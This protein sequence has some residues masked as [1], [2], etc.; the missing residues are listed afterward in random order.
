MIDLKPTD[1]FTLWY[2]PGANYPWEPLG[3]AA[4]SA[5]LTGLMQTKRSGEFVMMPRGEHP[6]S[7]DPRRVSSRPANS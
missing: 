2:R 5:E 3:S 1:R 6:Q 4:S 7:S